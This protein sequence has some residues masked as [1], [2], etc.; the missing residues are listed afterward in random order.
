[1]LPPQ[2]QL[3]S[4]KQDTY[5]N[6]QNKGILFDHET[7]SPFQ[8]GLLFDVDKHKADKTNHDSDNLIPGDSLTVD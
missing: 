4:G 3:H 5:P 6:K 2:A 8:S 7:G 1:M